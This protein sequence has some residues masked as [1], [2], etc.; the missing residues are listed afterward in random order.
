MSNCRHCL[1]KVTPGEHHKHHIIFIGKR[2]IREKILESVSELKLKDFPPV[3]LKLDARSP[4]PEV[5]GPLDSGLIELGKAKL[6]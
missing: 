2:Q 6:S 1:R 3:E 4:P 5:R